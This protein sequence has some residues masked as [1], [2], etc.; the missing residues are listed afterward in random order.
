[1]VRRITSCDAGQGRWQEVRAHA[2]LLK[3]YD[4]QIDVL[5]RPCGSKQTN[6]NSQHQIDGGWCKLNLFSCKLVPAETLSA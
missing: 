4:F 2:N 6:R 3:R 1:M 5:C